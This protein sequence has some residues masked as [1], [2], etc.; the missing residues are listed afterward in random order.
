MNDLTKQQNSQ[1]QSELEKK[2][3]TAMPPNLSSL[4]HAQIPLGLSRHDMLCRVWVMS[5]LPIDVI[6]LH[7]LLIFTLK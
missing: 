5:Q 2:Y 4:V 6:F 3:V 7:K 1:L